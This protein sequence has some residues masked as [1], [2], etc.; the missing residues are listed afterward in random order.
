M[1]FQQSIAK[2]A[3]IL[4]NN[5]MVKLILFVLIQ[6]STLMVYI[7]YINLQL[8]HH[9]E[10]TE[11]RM[12]QQNKISAENVYKVFETIDAELDTMAVNIPRMPKTVWGTSDGYNYLKDTTEKLKPLLDYIA[13]YSAKG[14]TEGSSLSVFPKIVDISDRVYFKNASSGKQKLYYGPFIGRLSGVWTYASIRRLSTSDGIF[15]G[16][17]L[18][19]VSLEH[20]SSICNSILRDTDLQT[21]I[22]NSDNKILIQ[23]NNHSVVVSK[24]DIDF[25]ASVLGGKDVKILNTGIPSRSETS[26]EL[27]FSSELQNG[28]GIKIISLISKDSLN[29]SSSSIHVESTLVVSYIIIAYLGMFTLYLSALLNSIDRRVGKSKIKVIQTTNYRKDDIIVKLPEDGT[30]D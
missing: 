27:F 16:V 4:S 21:F 1:K 18:V 8:N 14:T 22:L 25:H 7:N 30:L 2:V 5:L 20:L 23:C 13:V 19:A 17:L 24:T 3:L 15:D 9:K 6:I 29:A 28:S 12:I 10:E 11:L 26:N